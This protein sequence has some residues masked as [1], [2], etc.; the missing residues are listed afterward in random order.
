[1]HAQKLYYA[2]DLVLNV[3]RNCGLIFLRGTGYPSLWPSKDCQ[4]PLDVSNEFT[5]KVIDGILS[6]DLLT[7]PSMSLFL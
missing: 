4:E 5:F 1:M 3:L 2:F 7:Y 6:G